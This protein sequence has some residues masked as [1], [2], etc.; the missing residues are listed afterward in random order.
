MSQSTGTNSTRHSPGTPITNLFALA[1][2]PL[3]ATSTCSTD[4]CHLAD[5]C[6]PE[7]IR[8]RKGVVVTSRIHPG[9]SNASWYVVGRFGVAT[10]ARL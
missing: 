8:L 2:A 6:P 1:L 4:R 7:E 5:G 9:E 10:T 3:S